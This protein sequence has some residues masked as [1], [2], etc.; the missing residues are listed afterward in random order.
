MGHNQYAIDQE[1]IVRAVQ[2]D[3]K[4]S[5]GL[6]ARLGED[7]SDLKKKITSTISRGISTGMTFQQ[8]AQQ[9][10]NQTNIGYNNAVRITRTEG[11]RIQVQSGMD[12]CYKAKDRG[13]DVVKQWDSTLDMRTRDSHVQVDGEVRELDEKFSNGLRFPADPHGAAAEVVN[14]RCAL[15]QRARWAVDDSFTK[16][17]G[18]SGEIVDFSD[19]DD[20]NEFKKQY[21]GLAAKIGGNGIP[22]HEE[23]QFVKNI[24]SKD[25]KAV[26]KELKDFEKS[27]INE[28]IETA[29]VITKDGEVF[30]CFGVEDRVFPDFDL[31]DKLKGASVSHNHPIDETSYTFSVPDL[32]LFMEYDLE[33]LR[34]CDK[35]YTYEF[36]RDA[37]KIDDFPEEWM[38]EE[39][40][41]H[42][43]IIDLAK[44]YGIGY[45]RWEN[46]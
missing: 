17:N 12:A 15:L 8:M 1:A 30:K 21:K 35:K 34:G 45:R 27:A 44:K 19:I 20:Y 33:V 18:Y 38:N 28:S 10:M 5:Q 4:I 24:N 26:N 41:A 39:N 36:T 23:P 37:T 14:C 7:V 6:Y 43:Q 22:E 3:S 32:S 2:T 46:E 13:A 29:C 31:K 25:K 16:M 40:F 42:S 9:L 11:H